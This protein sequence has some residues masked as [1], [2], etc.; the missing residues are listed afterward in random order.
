MQ[1][2]LPSRPELQRRLAELSLYEFIVQAWPTIEPGTTFLENWHLRLICEHLEA[3]KAGEITRLIINQP[4]RTMKS[5]STTVMF[6]VWC[7]IDRPEMRWMFSSYSADLAVD[8]SVARRRILESDWYRANWPG[9]KLTTDQNIKSAYENDRRGKMVATSVGSKATGMGGNL[10]CDDLLNA[11]DAQSEVKRKGANE[12]FDKTLAT[13]LDDK[14]RDFIIIVMQRLFEDDLTGHVLAR[15]SEHEWTHLCLPERVPERVRVVFPRSGREHV[16]EANS[17][18]WPEREGEKELA[19]VKVLLGTRDFNAQYQQ[20]P[21]PAEGSMFKAEWFRYW[22]TLPKLDEVIQSWDLSF[23][24]GKDADYVV[25]SIWGKAGAECYLL[26]QVRA[27]AD[28]PATLRLFRL[29]SAKWPQAHAK[30]VERAANGAALIATLRKEIPGIIPVVPKGSK[31]VRAQA[32]T[33]AAEA[34]NIYLPAI[35]LEPLRL[36]AWVTEWI[37]ELTRFPVGRFDDQVDSASQALARLRK[38]SLIATT[39]DG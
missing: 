14:M 6:P 25:G 16:R 9:L 27:Q 38:P 35:S 28:F 17:I 12:F 7:W 23:S 33:A 18:M 34:G 11:R 4:P 8:H 1:T 22:T 10:I 20:E 19:S 39:T 26:D 29:M 31:E 3:V 13:R 15:D 21:A 5:I 30:L 24:G 37:D 2:P 36:D 32:A